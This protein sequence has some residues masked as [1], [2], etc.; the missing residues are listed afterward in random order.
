MFVI[1]GTI[2]KAQGI[3]I[4]SAQTNAT[5]F[6]S[7]NA[8]SHTCPYPASDIE[9]YPALKTKITY[10]HHFEA[11]SGPFTPDC[12]SAP[13]VFA[14]RCQVLHSATLSCPLS[15]VFAG[16]KSSLMS[17][18]Q[19][20]HSA[21]NSQKVEFNTKTNYESILDGGNTHSLKSDIDSIIGNG[22]SV[23]VFLK[24]TS[25]LISDEVLDY[26]MN[27][28]IGLS[29]TDLYSV[30]V[31]YSPLSLTLAEELPNLSGQ[32]SGLQISELQTLQN[33]LSVRDELENEVRFH[34]QQAELALN[35]MLS[36][37]LYDT[38]IDTINQPQDSML[39]YLLDWNSNWAKE[40]QLN[41]YWQKEEF[42]LAQQVITS[43]SAEAH[44]ENTVTLYQLLHNA[45]AS[46]TDIFALMP[47]TVLIDSIALDTTKK[48]YALAR[49]LMMELTGKQYSTSFT[50]EGITWSRSAYNEV[51]SMEETNEKSITIYPNPSN[52]QFRINGLYSLFTS[53]KEL[54]Q[55]YLFD[56]M[57]K[58]IV[59]Q[60]LN[61]ANEVEVQ[62][63]SDLN[64]VYH[65]KVSNS[66]G[67]QFVTKLI[68]ND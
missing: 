12:Y 50:H 10:A 13:N 27:H 11:S 63:P 68:L 16:T 25:P 55:L 28:P 40:Q 56:N 45:F 4:P 5:F 26:C 58:L 14:L 1:E 31:E 29:S 61:N 18:K 8:L 52:G 23:N 9:I 51:S 19:T 62:L 17:H 60:W 36:L 38:T 33:G 43:L 35:E 54:L 48:G 46:D 7:G 42:T 66:T 30:L 24:Y 37:F 53:E 44:Y 65:L 34:E 2:D 20:V 6:P 22:D 41:I 57:G 49:G 64:G 15:N 47:D 39:V 32:L 21:Y 3:C 59:E 67:K